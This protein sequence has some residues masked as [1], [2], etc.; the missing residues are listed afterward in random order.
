[1]SMTKRYLMSLAVTRSKADWIFWI[2]V[3]SMSART[4]CAAQRSRRWVSAMPADEGAGDTATKADEA[5]DGGG[6][7]ISG[8]DSDEEDSSASQAATKGTLSP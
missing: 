6:G 4:L 7:M 2:G 8:G 1:M 5:G 3:S